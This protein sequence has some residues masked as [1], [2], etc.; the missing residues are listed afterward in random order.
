MIHLGES[1]RRMAW[2]GLALV[3]C[4]WL[5]DSIVDFYVFGES[6]SLYAA[7]FQPDPVELW[8]RTMA[9]L[10]FI[11]FGIYAAFLLDRAEGVEKELRASNAEL[12]LLK[13]DFER[14]AEVD[15]LTGV[16]NRR[17]FHDS[18]GRAL[19]AAS[20]HQHVFALL[21]IDIDHFKDINDRFGHQVGDEVLRILC[22][23]IDSTIRSTDQLFR[24]GGEEFCL[25]AAV[26]DGEQSGAL[27]EKVRQVVESNTFPEVGKVTISIGI[28]HFKEGDTQHNIY[29]RADEALYQAKH[30]GRNCV[31]CG[32]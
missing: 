5:V 4:M 24:V 6:E 2:S 21:M 29:S 8:M 16:Y 14:L 3:P 10:M 22:N 28:A 18:L 23:L 7:F 30:R 11:S 13:S 15:P 26:Q 19:A 25:I 20:R 1:S 12:E 32:E 9:S 31:M 27:A 17:K